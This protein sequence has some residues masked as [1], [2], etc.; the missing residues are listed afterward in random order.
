MQDEIWKQL[1]DDEKAELA[2]AQ[3]HVPM[4][5]SFFG[6]PCRYGIRVVKHEVMVEHLIRDIPAH[7]VEVCAEDIHEC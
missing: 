5:D 7:F 3:T 4:D 6:G 2:E 1:D